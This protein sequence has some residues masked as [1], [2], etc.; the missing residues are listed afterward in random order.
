MPRPWASSHTRFP[1]CQ[2]VQNKASC[3]AITARRLLRT[4]QATINFPPLFP[5]PKSFTQISSLRYCPFA[6][7][8][9]PLI[10]SR[11]EWGFRE[12]IQLCLIYELTV[13]TAPWWKITLGADTVQLRRENFQAW[14][15][16]SRHWKA[17]L[18][19]ILRAWGKACVMDLFLNLKKYINLYT[20]QCVCKNTYTVCKNKYEAYIYI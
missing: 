7:L 3:S 14:S 12:L 6:R 9:H 19:R 2:D 15:L 10:F 5:A 11:S 16:S 8:I 13:T 18:C 17:C 4:F 1:S 20:M